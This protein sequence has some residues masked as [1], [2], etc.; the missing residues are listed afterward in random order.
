MSHLCFSLKQH[1]K[2]GVERRNMITSDV[3][4]FQI[5]VHSTNKGCM[6]YSLCESVEWKL[7][8]LSL[9][10]NLLLLPVSLL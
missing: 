5:Q 1:R 3:L 9:K 10:T 7:F 2:K 6:K 8:V 4:Q